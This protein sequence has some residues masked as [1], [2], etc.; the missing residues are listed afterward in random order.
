VRFHG[1][2][3][4]QIM[5][6][7][8]VEVMAR[9]MMIKAVLVMLVV[10]GVVTSMIVKFIVMIS[11]FSV[12]IVVVAFSSLLVVIVF[13]IVPVRDDPGADNFNGTAQLEVGIVVLETENVLDHV[14]ALDNVP[15]ARLVLV[16][17]RVVGLVDEEIAPRTRRRSP[18][19]DRVLG[20]LPE[21]VL[22]LHDRQPVQS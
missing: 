2:I 6:L 12:M 17:S 9:V 22:V 7:L 1:G 10:L 20:V 21:I 11:M 8:M 13:V 4:M 5:R 18:E 14:H 16:G 15:E 19:P 3:V